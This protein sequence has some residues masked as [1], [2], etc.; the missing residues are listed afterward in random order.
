VAEGLN[1]GG[2][3]FVT[4]ADYEAMSRRAAVFVERAVRKEPELL[5]CLATGS[6]PT[7]MYQVLGETSAKE[8]SLFSRATVI[9]L[10]E[11]GGLPPE[12][13]AT[14]ETY[15]RRHVLAPLG[16]TVDRYVGFRADA[17]DP[18]AECE[19]VA[20][21]LG[22]RRIGLSVLGLGVNG[23]LGF[24]EP[25]DA[26]HAHAHVASLSAESQAHPM[27]RET[28]AVVSFG[29]TLGMADLLHSRRVLLLVNGPHKREPLRRLL[30]GEITTR[31]PASLLWLHPDVTCVFDEAAAGAAKGPGS[32]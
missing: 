20:A 14:C 31:F 18:R 23:H 28:G 4:T 21:A 26:L 29:L 13:P 32:A 10:D 24:N 30:S 25:G 7:R 12:H 5:L 11:W 15:L 27:V 3:Q 22:G 19:R 2:V 16:V 9:K 6:S 8:P 17:R 1:G